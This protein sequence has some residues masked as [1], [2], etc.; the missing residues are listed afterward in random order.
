MTL[1]T[2]NTPRNWR[3]FAARAFCAQWFWVFNRYTIRGARNIPETGPFILASNHASFIDPPLLSSAL[4]KDREI[5]FFARKSLFKGWFGRLIASLN[6]VP[7]D[8]DGESD[9]SAFRTVFKLLNDGHGLLLFPEGTRTPDGRLQVPRKGLGLIACRTGV[10]II[11]ARVCGTY[12]YWGRK[13]KLPRL[14]A[15]LG[16]VFGPALHPA[17]YD[18]GKNHPERF[19][20]ASWVATAAIAALPDLYPAL[21]NRK[22]QPQHD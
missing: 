3:H 15:P 7:V 5:Y 21:P 17:Q 9:L 11:P 16:V 20:V 12:T 10:P 14:F 18:P 8:R 19:Q 2:T 1:P 6:A 13:Q 22:P 4:P